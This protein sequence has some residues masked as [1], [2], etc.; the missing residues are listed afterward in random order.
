MYPTSLILVTSLVYFSIDRGDS[1]EKLS[2]NPIL[3]SLIE[4]NIRARAENV[5]PTVHNY[6]EVQKELDKVIKERQRR[7]GLKK[8]E[9]R[10]EKERRL[11]EKRKKKEEE[12]RIAQSVSQ[13][14]DGVWL[15][16]EVTAYTANV[17][18]TNKNPGHP[19]YGITA[20]GET[21]KEG[22]T[23]SCPPE[24]K[25]G[26]E[27][28]IPHFNNTFTC[29]D[30]GSAII[31]NRLDVYMEDLDRALQFGRKKLKVKVLNDKE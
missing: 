18:S 9:E 14:E 22:R 21:V 2:P 16:F 28:Y 10:Q 15:T 4:E 5:H 27:M 24:Y 13:K 7:E 17:E 19:L 11:E 8:S 3:D 23:L 31:G 1:E 20:N 30:R 26:T 29:V 12:K 6:L 25:F